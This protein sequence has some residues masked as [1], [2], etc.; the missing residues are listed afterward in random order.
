MPIETAKPAHTVISNG[1]AGDAAARFGR[2]AAVWKADTRFLSNV[3]RKAM[4]PAY[5]A[6][7][8]MGESAIPLILR[9]LAENGPNDWFWALSAITEENPITGEIAGNMRAMTEAWLTWG[10]S[11]LPER[12]TQEDERCFPNLNSAGY[13]VESP[14]DPTYNCI[15]FAAGDTTRKWDCLVRPLPGYYWPTNARRGDD[16]EALKSAFE[17]IGYEKC[18]DGN[19]EDGFEKVALYADKSGYWTHAAKQ[20]LDGRWLSKLGDEEDIRH[21]TPNC[22]VGSIYGEIVFFMRR[23]VVQVSG[24]FSRVSHVAHVAGSQSKGVKLGKGLCDL[25]DLMHSQQP[26]IL[27]VGW[28]R[29]ANFWV[30][31]LLLNR[32]GKLKAVNFGFSR[33]APPVGIRPR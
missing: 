32:E 1:C 17:A 26:P 30:A 14:K 8:G 7:I 20:E 24:N 25:L 9:D 6:V 22:F 31:D 28:H 3:T 11:G 4:H 29:T 19:P 10:E 33:R 16:P 5:Q 23:R 12:L 27:Q 2:L 21:N 15:A 13:R 18:E